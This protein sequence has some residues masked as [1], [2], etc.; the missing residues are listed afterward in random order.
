MEWLITDLKD[1]QQ[2]WSL[3]AAKLGLPQ[4]TIKAIRGEQKL[5][6]YQWKAALRA[7]YDRS[8]KPCIEEVVAAL[9]D[10]DKVKLASEI[11]KTWNIE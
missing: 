3:L 10:M 7:W 5:T 1:I 11:A 4:G 8:V 6:W 2:D 9:K